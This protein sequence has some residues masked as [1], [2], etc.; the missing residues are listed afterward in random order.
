MSESSDSK[1]KL[2][3]HHAGEPSLAGEADLH[4][5]RPTKIVIVGVGMVGSSFAYSLL[6]SGLAAEIVLIDANA[7]RAEGEAMDLNHAVPFAH[8]TRI[9]AGTYADCAG[10]AITVIAAGLGQKPGESRLE[11]VKKN[12]AIFAEIVPQIAG[13][14][15]DGIIVV[16]TNPV[17]VLT[18]VTIEKSGLP[19]HRVFGS[20]TILDT[21]RFRYMLSEHLGVDPR[22]VHAYIIGEHGDSEVPVWSLANVAGMRLPTFC[23]ENGIELASETMDR[24]FAQ[25]RDAAYEIISRKG[26]T[27]YA[28]AAGLTRIAEA[29]VRNQRTVLSI[30]S[31]IEDYYGIDGVCLSLPTVLSRNGIERVLRL[32]LSPGEARGVRKS[33]DVLRSTMA[34]L[35]SGANA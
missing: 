1:P 20:G 4:T 32:E 11:L 10:A 33:A 14:N 6:L 21:A 34:S 9:R 15:P 27:Y 35:E 23:A 12:A 13:A 22:S 25:T 3:V 2:A 7:Q 8:P 5:G 24:I 31:L 16:A 18:H 19:K 17:D 28:V 30:S 29:I 26:A